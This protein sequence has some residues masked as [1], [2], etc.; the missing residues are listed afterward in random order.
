[1]SC[2][3]CRYA[4]NGVRPYQLYQCWRR[5]NE[6]CWKNK[7][8]GRQAGNPHRQMLKCTVY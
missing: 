1:M 8:V 4:I 2:D 6:T 5:G 3:C 7:N